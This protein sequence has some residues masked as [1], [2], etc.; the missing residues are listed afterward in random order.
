M[1]P[2]KS[3]SRDPAPS[4]LAYRMQRL[5]LTP[6]VRRGFTIGLPVFTVVLIGGLALADQGR[7]EAFAE[8]IEEVSS[9]FRNRKEFQVQTM[10]IAGASDELEQDVR[11]ILPIDFPVSSFDLDLQAMQ[12]EI[13][14]LDA[15]ERADLRVRPGGMLEIDV[16]ERMPAVIWRTGTGLLLL[17][18]TGHRTGPLPRR[19]LRPDL[20]IVSGTGAD[21]AAAEALELIQTAAPLEDRV[22]GLARIGERRWDVVLSGGQRIMLPEAGAAA[23]LEE[24][25]ALHEAEELFARDVR[26]VDLRNPERPTV[27]MTPA[28]AQSMRQI[29]LTE[30]GDDGL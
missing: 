27:R 12:A 4:R 18:A 11:E 7:R 23:A 6:M 30:L 22:R 1:R 21:A 2:M 26:A 5:A 16:A 24:V 29:K 20:P 13:A 19:G 9:Q 28:A 14:A 25:I 10:S 3:T 8:R 15:V 17:D